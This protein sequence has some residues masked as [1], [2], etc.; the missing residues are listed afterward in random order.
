MEKEVVITRRFRNQT[1]RIYQYLLKDFSPK[2]AS[3]FLQKV[4]ER[5]ELI[6]NHPTIG[7]LFD[8]RQNPDKKPY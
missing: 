8:M 2:T 1:L 5:I 7:K 6:S 3:H 4:E